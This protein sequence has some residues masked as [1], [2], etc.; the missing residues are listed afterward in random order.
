[1]LPRQDFGLSSPVRTVV[2]LV[3]V[4]DGKVGNIEGV[5]ELRFERGL[6]VAQLIPLHIVKEG[7]ALDFVGAVGVAGVTEAIEGIAE[8]AIGQLGWEGEHEE[9]FS[10]YLRIRS[11]GAALRRMSSGN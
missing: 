5:G 10:T 1:M 9:I 7:V 4:L 11:S 8:E 6:D 3:D 2:V